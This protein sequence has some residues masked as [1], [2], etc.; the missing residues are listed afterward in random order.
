L[1][2]TLTLMGVETPLMPLIVRSVTMKTKNSEPE[3][4][5]PPF[6]VSG[7]MLRVINALK[8]EKKNLNQLKVISGYSGAPAMLKKNVIA[9]LIDADL[10]TRKGEEYS[11]TRKGEQLLTELLDLRE[12]EYLDARNLESSSQEDEK[13]ELGFMQS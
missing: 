5:Y 7:H 8:S 2:V 11:C 1:R 4:I 10:V 3:D 6:S 13:T 12:P 9:K